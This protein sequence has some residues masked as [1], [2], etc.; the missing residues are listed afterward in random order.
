MFASLIIVLPSKFKGGEV[1]VSHG[2]EKDVF[3]ISPSSEF[4]TS[5]LAWYTDVTH[6]VKPV[7][8][9]YRLAIS[10][11]LVNTLPG[12]PP[13]L[14]PDVHSAVST[15][16]HVFRKWNEGAYDKA[17]E[18]IAYLLNHQY[19]SVSLQF[20]A[21][22]GKDATLVSSIRPV[23]DNQGISLRLGLLEYK[24]AGDAGE[25]YGYRS[26]P[27]MEEVHETTYSIK[28]LYD[29]EGDLVEGNYIRL[30]PESD[31]IPQDPGFEDQSPDDN[32]FEGYTGNVSTV[33]SHTTPDL[34]IIP[35]RR[36]DNIL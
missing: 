21:L 27:R 3:N 17:P 10:Y 29:L 2:D 35:G 24:I 23:A 4:T 19:S 5:A 16:E 7:T 12:L 11:N 30:H 36:A 22:K 9:G 32:E 34:T 25:G 18:T 1:H 33:P 13:P 8:S 31:M 20:A 26:K 6:Q 28:G 15:V 14:L